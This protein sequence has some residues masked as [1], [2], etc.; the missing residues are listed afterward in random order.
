MI[1]R[2]REVGQGRGDD[3][4]CLADAERIPTLPFADKMRGADAPVVEAAVDREGEVVVDPVFLE[5]VRDGVVEVREHT[6]A[7]E[8]QDGEVLR[9]CVVVAEEDSEREPAEEV[10]DRLPLPLERAEEFG[11]PVRAGTTRVAR[12]IWL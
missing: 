1:E 7:G 4:R 12:G 3:P 10:G 9:V 8:V 2:R 5:E 6:P 11:D